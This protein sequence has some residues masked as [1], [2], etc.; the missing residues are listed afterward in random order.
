MVHGKE[1]RAE[2]KLG[3]SR[4]DFLV[5]KDYVEVK[6]LLIDLPVSKARKY[7]TH[8]KFDSFERL[9]KHFRDLGD[10]IGKESR[11]IILLCYMF[12]AEPFRPPEQDSSNS[13][14]MR[15]ARGAENKGVENWQINLKIDKKGVEL[16]DYFKLDL[17]GAN[18]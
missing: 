2:V 13:R 15:A 1:V 18:Q 5:G 14:I 9:I 16:L 7:K 10:S 8:S 11:A 12:D 4:I 3:D 6:T 17:F